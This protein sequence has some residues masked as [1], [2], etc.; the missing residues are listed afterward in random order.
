MMNQARA[1]KGHAIKID[2]PVKIFT[3]IG[4]E[5]LCRNCLE[6]WPMDEEFFYWQWMKSKKTG[7]SYKQFGSVCKACYDIYYGRRK[8][9]KQGTIRSYHEK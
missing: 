9:R 3:E 4:A 1:E 2:L 5:K 7:E 6:Y 8:G